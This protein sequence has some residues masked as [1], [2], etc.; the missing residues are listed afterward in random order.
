MSSDLQATY[1][2]LDHLQQHLTALRNL[3]KEKQI[4]VAKLE[5]PRIHS[6]ADQER[7]MVEALREIEA[8]RDSL[9]IPSADAGESHFAPLLRSLDPAARS[10]LSK[11][12][13]SIKVLAKRV[14]LEAATSWLLAYRN[15]QYVGQILEI[16]ANAGQANN[17][18]EPDPGHGHGLCLDST[19]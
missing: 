7:E 14:K 13:D 18:G 11:R 10:A 1:E 3:Q 19:A 16:M 9:P 15:H 12:L 5:S 2:Y 8:K 6:L 17:L 4:A